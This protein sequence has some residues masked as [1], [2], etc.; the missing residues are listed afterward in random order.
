M[1]IGELRKPAQKQKEKRCAHDVRCERNDCGNCRPHRERD[2]F[3][4]GYAYNLNR[5][6]YVQ[7]N[8]KLID[9]LLQ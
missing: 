9:R 2:G 8:S 4:R 7:F 1:R 3:G 6:R 5:P